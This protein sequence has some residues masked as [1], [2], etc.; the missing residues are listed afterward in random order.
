M[1]FLSLSPGLDGYTTVSEVERSV[2]GQPAGLCADAEAPSLG[3]PSATIRGRT[4]TISV[5]QP[6]GSLLSTRCAGPL[7]G[8]LA[9]AGPKATDLAPGRA[10]R[11]DRRRSAGQ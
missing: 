7:D 2:A 10:A 1:A 6:G 5:L 11:P 3:A 9:G 8:D 4:L